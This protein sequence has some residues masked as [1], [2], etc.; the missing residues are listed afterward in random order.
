MN[1]LK[2]VGGI[3]TV[4]AIAFGIFIYGKY[5]SNTKIGVINYPNFLSAKIATANNN[6]HIKIVPL[7]PDSLTKLNSYDMLLIFGMGIELPV[8]QEQKIIEAGKKG[9]KIY[10]QSST[11][12]NLQ[13]TNIEGKQ[14]DY[15]SEY[16]DN[17]GQSNFR[18]M[19][20]YV[21]RDVDGKRMFTDSIVEPAEIPSDVL[22]HKGEEATFKT[23]SE[24]EDYCTENN[25]HQKERDRVMIITS[26]PGPF[27]ANRE[28]LNSLI[29]ELQSRELNVYP[30]AGFRGRLNFMKEINPSLIVYMPHGRLS[31]GGGSAKAIE[32]WLRKQ[33]V[34]VLCPI[35]V[36]Q[37]YDDWINDRQGMVG[38]Y[39]SQSVTM[40]EFDG[41]TVPYAVFAQYEDENGL[42]LFRA[43]PGRLKKFGD[44]VSKHLLLQKKENSEKKIAI[45]YFKGPG[46]NA[47]EASNME[48]LPSLHN[49]LKSLKREGY[50]L[51]DLP[52]DYENFKNRVMSQ[53]PVLGPYAEGAFDSFLQSGDPELIPASEYEDWCKESLPKELYEEVENRYGKAPGAY[54]SVYDDTTDYLAVARVKFGNVMLLPQPLPSIGE[55][56]FQLIHGAKVAPPHAYIAPYMWIQHAFKADAVFHF[57]THGSLEFTPGKQIALSDYDWTDPLIGTSPHLYVYT[58]SNVGEGMIAK[59]RSYAALQTHLTPPFIEAKVNAGP[60]VLQEKIHHYDKAS[61]SLKTQYALAV[62]ELVVNENIHKDLGLDSIIS[63]PYSD[64]EMMKLANY[65]EEIEHEK[66]TGGLYTMGVPYSSDKLD[67]TVK[68]ML[69]DA[70]AWNLSELDV[71]KGTTSRKQVENKLFFNERYRNP[72]QGYIGDVIQGTNPTKMFYQIVAD[73]DIKRAENWKVKQE[74]INKRAYHGRGHYSST[75]KSEADSVVTDFDR[76]KLRRLIVNILPDSA[77]TEFIAKLESDKEYERAIGLLSPSKFARAQRMA[78]LIP[79]MDEALKI[80]TDSVVYEILSLIRK[81]ELRT[82][83]LSYLNDSNLEEE[84]EKEKFIQDSI[85]LAEA[86][87]KPKIEVLNYTKSGIQGFNLDDLE[88]IQSMLDFYSTNKQK[89]IVLLEGEPSGNHSNLLEYLSSELNEINEL[90]KSRVAELSH[91]EETFANAVFIVQ[92]T[93]NDALNKEEQLLNSPESEFKAILNSLNGGYTAPSP[94]GDPVAN[95]SSVPT[96]RNMF[97]VN[98]EQ[99]PTRE[100]WEVGKKLGENLLTDYRKKHNDEYPKKISFTLWSSSFIETEG[101]TIAQILYMLGVEPIWDPYGRVKNVRLLSAEE[102]GRPRI[103]VVVQTSGQLRDLAASRLFIINQAINKVAL[104]AEPENNYV[105]KGMHDAEKRL[106]EKGFSPKQARNFST[107]RVFGGVNGNYGTGIMGMVEN[108]GRWDST[109]AVAQ[110]Y[111]NNMGAVYADEE[112]WGDF[113]A[114]VF[115][116]ALLN[117]EAVVQPRQSNTWGAL[118]LD[119][120]YEFMGGLNLAIKEVT[121]NDAESYFNDFRNASNPRVQGLKEAVW[122]ETHTTLLNP[123]YIQEYMKGGATSAETFAETFRNTFGWNVMKPSAIE[124]RLWDELYNT[125]V[126]DKQNLNIHQFFERENPYALQEMTAVMLETVRK[127]MWKATPEQIDAMAN[128]HAELVKE[129]EAG[130]S[131]FVCDNQ[132]LKDF[133]SGKLSKEPDNS[134]SE[135]ISRVRETSR[136]DLKEN[137]VLEKEEKI[138]L[139]PAPAKYG[140]NPWIIAIVSLTLLALIAL[141]IRKRKKSS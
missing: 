90:V 53:G 22:F 116:A 33:N 57:G 134:Y 46:K 42:L 135:Q 8:E 74:D 96:G 85:L 13:L 25:L 122:V 93:L 71:V 109:R 92:N 65:L 124:N 80:A 82:L 91:I 11:N 138:D 141:F 88:N 120:V 100:A 87:S 36:M 31:M 63:K 4:A 27:N 105:S 103:D 21:R 44:I 118:S 112:S 68:L 62:K 70:L 86:I 60:K 32:D 39:L 19:L 54:M 102:L 115:E 3:V 17:G 94:G 1:K 64:G 110:T 69:V 67:E 10:L 132:K 113:D 59:R 7:Q 139:T 5:L 45:V 43:I 55:N 51:G 30:I 130:C 114:G 78:K 37:K 24:F 73:K 34:P 79:A 28:H 106:I 16:L 15:I 75:K 18:N 49:L 81:P 35:S 97:S 40:P 89:L 123:R 38:G 129:Y 125:Y 50:N 26:V 107:K 126:K 117:T 128:L 104:E 127:G 133:I 121:G 140:V 6:K 95:P 48:V 101:S 41:G 98:A 136:G 14:L 52:N 83:A 137:I 84:V 9:T 61:G 72:S 108:S 131:G 119:H 77:K 47:L 56:T 2:L 23:V 29:D 66:I 12:P 111:I 58:I 76:E 20:N 99:T